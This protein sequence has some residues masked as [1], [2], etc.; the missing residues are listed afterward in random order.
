MKSFNINVAKMIE[1]AILAA[2]KV[3]ILIFGDYTKRI[4]VR[5]FM[6]SEATL[7][8]IASSKQIERKILRLTVVDLKERLVDGKIELYQWI[9]TGLMWADLF[10]NEME[11]HK[12]MKELLAKRSLWMKNDS[13]NR[14]QCVDGKINMANI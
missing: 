10:T 11:M 8:S 3:E 7:E 2:R 9:L 14:V 4:K 5:I 6:D 1:D 12:D 13:I